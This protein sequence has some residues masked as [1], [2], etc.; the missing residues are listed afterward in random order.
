MS[1]RD[2]LDL[3]L[4]QMAV[5]VL[6]QSPPNATTQ[7]G[8]SLRD[9]FQRKLFCEHCPE[10]Q[11]IDLLE[12]MLPTAYGGQP[13]GV[14]MVQLLMNWLGI[15]YGPADMTLEEL[16][17]N[18]SG[19]YAVDDILRRLGVAFS[20]VLFHWLLSLIASLSSN[21]VR[22]YE[23]GHFSRVSPEKASPYLDNGAGVHSVTVEH[24]SFGTSPSIK[25][26]KYWKVFRGRFQS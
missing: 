24:S 22:G 16:G 8:R 13:V 11:V 25:K 3:V 12:Q 5:L 2:V 20:P 15:Q 4:D 6:T 26:W 14:Y 17:H 10:S 23:T 9:H 21:E 19:A 7:V 18:L 1:S